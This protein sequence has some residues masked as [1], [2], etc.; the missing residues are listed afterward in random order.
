MAAALHLKRGKLKVGL[1]ERKGV[2]GLVQ[3]ARLVENYPGFPGGISG[4]RLAE[5]LERQLQE[6]GLKW[7]EEEIL[8]VTGQEGSKLRGR[9]GTYHSRYLILAT[10]TK[11]RPLSLKGVPL[12]YEV[13][14]L[15]EGL[16]QVAIVGGGDVAFDYALSCADRGMEVLLLVHSLPKAHPSLQG[17]VSRNP[18]IRVLYGVS[19][20][21]GEGRYLSFTTGGRLYALE[22]VARLRR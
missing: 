15:P 12:Y 1:F 9:H 4:R 18:R 10:G 8:E 5:L 13:V 11:P 21:K 19:E 20:L 3:N 14:E 6:V 2:G 16:R 22:V 7:I 17:E